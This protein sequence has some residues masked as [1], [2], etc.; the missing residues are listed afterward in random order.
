MRVLVMDRGNSSL[1]AAVFMEDRIVENV[2]LDVKGPDE[3][4]NVISES[5]A[6]RVVFSSVVPAWSEEVRSLL[7]SMGV[8]FLEVSHRIK[9]P[10][11][12][13]VDNPATLGSDRISLA[14]GAKKLGFKEAVI[15][16]VG[17]AITVDFL[18]ELGFEG[19]AIFPGPSLIVEALRNGA[20]RLK[21]VSVDGMK[22]SRL[23]G[24][25]TEEAVSSGVF[26]GTVGAVKE[27][28][29]RTKSGGKNGEVLLTG[30][31]APL[32]SGYIEPTPT[33]LPDLLFQGLYFLDL[34]NR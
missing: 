12:L 24:R 13:L 32:L 15:I 29:I 10:F 31:Y 18:S 19:G 4:M 2:K 22:P 21:N 1:K 26:W 7:I 3:L 8:D 11:E 28:L 25:N 23:P 9:L 27:L 16:D 17:T 6:D 33:M 20:S 14:A 34:L 5:S 30:G